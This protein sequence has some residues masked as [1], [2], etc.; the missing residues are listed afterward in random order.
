[1]KTIQQ[2]SN[3]IL[4]TDYLLKNSKKNVL[5]GPKINKVTLNIG[6][7]EANINSS[8]ILIP[9]LILKVLSGEKPK[10]TKAR[11]SIANFK[12]RE[13]KIIGCKKT[14]RGPSMHFFLENFVHV[15]LPIL[16]ESKTLKYK[17]NK[18]TNSLTI[19]IKDCSIFPELENQ[20]DLLKSIVGFNVTINYKE[21]INNKDNLF[22]S[23]LKIPFKM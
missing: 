15:I 3:T 18:G 4:K 5:Q 17:I 8:K 23:G 22:F 11:K 21:N 19:G 10:P 2:Y 1:M 7:R 6:V 16:F 12:L 9:L 14:L 13:G 20:Y